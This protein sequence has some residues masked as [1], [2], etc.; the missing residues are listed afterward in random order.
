MAINIFSSLCG[1]LGFTRLPVQATFSFV[2]KRRNF[3]PVLYYCS[4]MNILIIGTGNVAQ[5]LGKMLLQANHTILQVFGRNQQT[6]Y[7]C[8]VILQAEPI[9]SLNSINQQAEVCIIAT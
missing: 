4:I 7:E 5:V 1:M 6:L 2:S 8:A 9:A 3:A